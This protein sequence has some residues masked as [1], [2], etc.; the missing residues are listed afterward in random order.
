MIRLPHPDLYFKNKF[1]PI[2]TRFIFHSKN[3]F[4]IP[5]DTELY[6]TDISITE[7]PEYHIYIKKIVFKRLPKPYDTNCEDY[8]NSTRFQCLNDCYYKQYM[9]SIQC[10][11]NSESL[12]TFEVKQQ[13]DEKNITFCLSDDKY[14]NFK[15]KIQIKCDK[16]CL[17]SCRDYYYSTE[18]TQR[19]WKRQIQYKL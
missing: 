9:D 15:Y 11:P 19:T 2:E 7:H 10:I 6:L 5:T 17:V 18:Y 4:P 13:N 3:A 16:Q 14:L 1:T 12:Y 8:E